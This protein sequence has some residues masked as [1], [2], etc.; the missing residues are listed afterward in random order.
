[1]EFCLCCSLVDYFVKK[2]LD[3]AVDVNDNLNISNMTS[4]HVFMCLKQLFVSAL[5]ILVCM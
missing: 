2:E 5:Y 1:M 4:S 3:S